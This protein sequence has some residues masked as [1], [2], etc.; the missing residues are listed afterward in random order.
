M[1]KDLKPHSHGKKTPASAVAFNGVRHCKRGPGDVQILNRTDISR[2]LIRAHNA[3]I[4]YREPV[5]VASI[6]HLEPSTSPRVS[7][8]VDAV[9]YSYGPLKITDMLIAAVMGGTPAR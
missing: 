3:G 1:R 8:A 6:L 4:V 2:R 7:S 5:I 9:Q